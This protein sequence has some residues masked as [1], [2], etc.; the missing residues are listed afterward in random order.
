MLTATIDPRSTPFVARRDPALRLRDYEH[1]LRAWLSSGSV[2]R[3]VFIEN[4]AHDLASL[5]RIADSQDRVEVEFL[6]FEDSGGG[7]QRGKGFAELEIICHGL[8]NSRHL[9]ASRL[10]VKCTGRLFLRNARALL[11]RVSDSTVD[12]M[13]DI[14]RHLTFA[15]TRLFIATPEFISS[16]LMREREMIDDL[17]GVYFE[18]AMARATLKAVAGELVWLPF[19]IYPR[20]RGIA[21]TSGVVITDNIAKAAAK[22]LVYR[23]RHFV[24][25][26]Q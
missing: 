19:P 5:R 14:M 10:I 15:D 22:A 12:V 26:S 2:E 21:G 11:S 9:A 24:Y 1:A 7:E 6:S 16:Y 13:C 23:M 3:I 25:C 17:K 8:A 20:L 4:S 18:H